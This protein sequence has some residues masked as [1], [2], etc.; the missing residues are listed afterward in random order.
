M[1]THGRVVLLALALVW[2]AGLVAAA[3][4]TPACDT[5]P[6]PLDN[7]GFP[8]C[9]DGSWDVAIPGYIAMGVSTLA[10]VLAVAVLAVSW[11]RRRSRPA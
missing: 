8:D 5:E 11:L 3:I 4:A 10:I 1:R 7:G 6:D 9:G 2:V